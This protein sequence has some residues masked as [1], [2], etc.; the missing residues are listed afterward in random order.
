MRGP[1]I[2]F[3]FDRLSEIV[4]Q[5]HLYGFAVDPRP[6]TS[7]VDPTYRAEP[8]TGIV[9]VTARLQDCPPAVRVVLT[10]Q[11][12]HGR[13]GAHPRRGL[14]VAAYTYWIGAEEPAVDLHYDL[15]PVRHPEMPYHWHPPAV[16]AIRRP[17][18]PATP[19][20]AMRAALQLAADIERLQAQG[21]HTTADIVDSLDSA[22]Y[23]P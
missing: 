10:E 2:R 6:G 16:R 23:V 17:C 1:G 14:S 13:D 21:I 7:F 3:V 8:R 9:E 11:W 19:A 15:D 20:R 12:R 5:L 22:D 4:D 18:H